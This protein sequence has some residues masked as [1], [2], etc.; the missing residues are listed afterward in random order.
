LKKAYYA[1]IQYHIPKLFHANRF[2][3]MLYYTLF[4]GVF[5]REMYGVL[6]GKIRYLDQVYHDQGNLFLLVRNTHRLEKGLIMRP[7]KAVFATD[8]LEETVAALKAVMSAPLPAQDQQIQWFLDVMGSYFDAV[9][10]THPMIAKEKAT[11]EAI[12]AQ[13]GRQRAEASVRVPYYRF[14]ESPADIPFEQFLTL[15]RQRKSVRWFLDTPV[16]RELIDKALL[17]AGLAPSACN[18]Q[19]YEFRVFDQK[20]QVD[21]LS[22]IPMGTRGFSHNF[23]VFIVI[24]G[25]LD[26]YFDERDRHVIYVD[27]SLASMTFMLALETLG[28]SSC[29]I[30]WP[31]I[32]SREKRMDK[33]LGLQPH[34]RPIMCLAVGYPDP[35]GLVAYSEKRPL[36]EVRTYNV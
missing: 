35:E 2:T 15:A 36:D 1:L 9:D 17:A 22:Q 33:A 13:S 16:P 11:F 8:Y 20:E 30:N 6:A 5:R 10:P 19:P 32:E 18:R 27:G 3:A 28:L 14:K 25:N 24:V 12:L 21:L 29:P 7:R 4:S 23:P 34:Q 26:A 31:D